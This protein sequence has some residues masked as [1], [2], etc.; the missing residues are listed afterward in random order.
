LLSM[1]ESRGH[2]EPMVGLAVQLAP[3]GAEVR[4]WR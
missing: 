1:D 3:L 4:M 2:V